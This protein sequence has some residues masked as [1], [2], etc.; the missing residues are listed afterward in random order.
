MRGRAVARAAGPAVSGDDDHLPLRVDED[1]LAEDTARGVGAV[2]VGPPLVAV[3][4]AG[5]ADVGAP[6]G[7]SGQPAVGHGAPRAIQDEEAVARV[8]ACGGLHASAADFLPG[9]AEQPGG[10]LLHAARRPDLLG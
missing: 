3:A 2:V 1:P 5:L 8:V 7:G 9:A 4:A 6:G 10:L